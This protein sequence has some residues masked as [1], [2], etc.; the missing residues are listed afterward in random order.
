MEEMPVPVEQNLPAESPAA[1]QK[2]RTARVFAIIAFALVWTALGIAVV[3]DI[4]T[5]GQLILFFVFACFLAAA[6]FIIMFV[7]CIVSCMLIFGVYLLEQYGFWPVTVAAGLYHE[8]MADAAIA[9]ERI[10]IFMAVR[11]LLLIFCVFVFVFSII[12]LSMNKKAKKE[13][14]QGK[15]GLTTAFG[16]V[17]LILS[18]LGIG[19]AVIMILIFAL[20]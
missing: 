11:I 19:A 14:F 10:S 8:V 9:P 3:A 1:R 4:F 20:Q 16:V 7:L 18:I 6:A 12:A 13:G 15:R 2:G 5:F 17:S